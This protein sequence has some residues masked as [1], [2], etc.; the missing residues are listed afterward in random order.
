MMRPKMITEKLRQ[1]IRQAFDL[2]V[3]HVGGVCP[4]ERAELTRDALR[5]V[6]HD[7]FNI[8]DDYHQMQKRTTVILAR[9]DKVIKDLE[10]D[11]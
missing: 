7:V 8:L 6:E 2:A 10:G 1:E 3:A 4:P 5:R 11:P 9:I